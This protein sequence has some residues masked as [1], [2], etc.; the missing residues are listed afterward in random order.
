MSKS[1][2]ILFLST[3]LTLLVTV[4]CRKDNVCNCTVT[5][6]TTATGQWKEESKRKV[7]E[8]QDGKCE[9][10]VEVLVWP[11]TI[12]IPQ[13]TKYTSNGVRDVFE[14]K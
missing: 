14:C 10:R 2:P 4:G 13:G 9:D 1:L 6:E 3:I 7:K 5:R 12:T 8:I 11:N